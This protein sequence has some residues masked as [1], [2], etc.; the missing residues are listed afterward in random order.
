MSEDDDLVYKLEERNDMGTKKS[1]SNKL[2]LLLHHLRN[3]LRSPRKPLTIN[4]VPQ[5]G[6]TLDEV[7]KSIS[8][9]GHIL[10]RWARLR[11][12][13]LKLL[14]SINQT[15]SPSASSHVC[16]SLLSIIHRTKIFWN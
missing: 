4:T 10:K 8:P 9:R 16:I 14:G 5:K 6:S 3:Q 15:P 2:P 7:T 11:P 13:S 1:W 12:V